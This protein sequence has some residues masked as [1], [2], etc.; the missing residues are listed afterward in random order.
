MEEDNTKLAEI[1][2]W[3]NENYGQD[4]P[5]NYDVF[6]GS[7][8]EII[9]YDDETAISTWSCGA[10][11]C[12]DSFIYFL[13]EDDGNWYVN[14]HKE[15]WGEWDGVDMYNIYCGYQ[16]HFN[17]AWADS[18]ADAMKRLS[19]YVKENGE[20]VYYEGIEPKKICYYY[21]CKKEEK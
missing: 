11:V 4:N 2:K 3:L 15:K 14:S 16:T 18:F 1:V 13:G 5:E 6:I 8:P 21:L 17:I 9:R 7:K 19:E 20:P 12:I 10:I